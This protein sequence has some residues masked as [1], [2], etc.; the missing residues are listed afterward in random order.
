MDFI[1]EF[2]AWF[3][4]GILIYFLMLNVTYIILV[5]I[6]FF[7]VRAQLKRKKV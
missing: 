4:S 6:S 7:Y 3:N 1:R 2:L 5:T